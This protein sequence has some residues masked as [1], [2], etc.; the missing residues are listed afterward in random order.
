MLK[1][2]NVYACTE[3]GE[4]FD[5]N[6]EDAPE[7]TPKMQS[8]TTITIPEES[9]AL[10][11]IAKLLDPGESMT[12]AYIRGFYKITFDP[13]QNLFNI[14][15]VAVEYGIPPQTSQIS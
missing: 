15:E 9:G 11:D 13:P 10:S 8:C 2:P 4:V 1:K 3:T 14:T 6:S 12:V 7:G 5:A